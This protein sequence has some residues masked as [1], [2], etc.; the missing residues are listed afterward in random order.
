MI[1][2]IT[3]IF[4][5]ANLSQPDQLKKKKGEMLEKFGI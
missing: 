2:K 1:V 5:N 3:A 4:S